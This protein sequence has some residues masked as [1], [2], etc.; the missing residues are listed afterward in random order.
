MDHQQ[1]NRDRILRLRE[2][3][4]RT[5]R[6]RSTIY[7]YMGAGQFPKCIPIGGRNVGWLES[8]IDA[9]IAACIQSRAQ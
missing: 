5:G 3:Q 2:V 4:H 7:E 9:W 6:S 1:R 8:E